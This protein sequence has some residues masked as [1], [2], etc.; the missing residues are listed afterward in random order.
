MIS[1]L[2]NSQLLGSCLPQSLR[3]KEIGIHP[4]TDSL[5]NDVLCCLCIIL[6]S[7]QNTEIGL[8]LSIGKC[9]FSKEVGTHYMYLL[10]ILYIFILKHMFYTTLYHIRISS[11]CPLSHLFPFGGELNSLFP[12]IPVAPQLHWPHAAP[13]WF[14]RSGSLQAP[15]AEVKLQHRNLITI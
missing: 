4:T 12:I 11:P 2:C 7:F 13:R 6:K 10:M 5:R 3:M 14:D 15:G 1:S 8:L 9:T